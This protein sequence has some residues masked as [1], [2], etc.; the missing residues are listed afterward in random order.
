MSWLQIGSI[1]WADGTVLI[2]SPE[3]LYTL[4]PAETFETWTPPLGGGGTLHASQ[5]SSVLLLDHLS[6]EGLAEIYV[7]RDTQQRDRQVKLLSDDWADLDAAHPISWTN[8][9]LVVGDP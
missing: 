3:S 6:P 8:G 9:M 2:A 5:S 4:E 1:R 7:Q